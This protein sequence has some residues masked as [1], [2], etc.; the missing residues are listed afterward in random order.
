[1]DGGAPVVVSLP[2][3]NSR[4]GSAALRA[5]LLL[6]H[7]DDHRLEPLSPG[8]ALRRLSTQILW[9]VWNETAMARTFAHL[10]RLVESVPAFVFSFAPRPDAISFLEEEIP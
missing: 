3:W 7:G 8:G 10:S 4:P 6:E 2:F 9:P 1:M 5:I